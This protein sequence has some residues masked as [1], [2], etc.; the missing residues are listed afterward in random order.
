MD[1]IKRCD[2]ALARGDG[3]AFNAHVR[4]ARRGF[5]AELVELTT[6]PEVL[7]VCRSAA[8][9]VP[10]TC[11]WRLKASGTPVYA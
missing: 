11:R 3:E 2:G 6:A 1:A 10:A 9:L 7:R 4:R 5:K 8:D